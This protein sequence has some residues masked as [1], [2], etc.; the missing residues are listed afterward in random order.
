M[1]QQTTNS[2]HIYE[3]SSYKKVDPLLAAGQHVACRHVQ[4]LS[5]S[6]IGTIEFLTTSQHFS[7]TRV[8]QY[9]LINNRKPTS[10]KPTAW[11]IKLPPPP[12]PSLPIFS[13]PCWEPNS[14]SAM[15]SFYIRTS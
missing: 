4:L 15:A 13:P 3:S 14:P 8:G 6:L 10:P 1:Q 11:G 5:V 2:T 12:A 9:T 7:H